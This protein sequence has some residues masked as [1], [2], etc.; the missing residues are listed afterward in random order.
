MKRVVW[1]AGVAA[2]VVVGGCSKGNF[3][4]RESAGKANV[5]RYPL[6]TN[7][8]TLDPGMVQD[9]D[10]IDFLQNVYEGLVG[11]GTDNQP[12]GLIAQNW[13]IKDGGKT[14][15]FHL[16]K[17]VKFFNG[18][19]VHADDFK[20]TYERN[21][22][23]QF[24]SPVTA[25]LDD[26]VGVKDE[27]AGKRNDIPGVKVIDPYTLEVDLVAPRPYFLGRFTYLVAAVLCKEAV[28][29]G[30]EINTT[31]QMVG[32]GPFKCAQFVP[33]QIVVLEA[34]KDYHDGAPQV[35]KIE[36]PIMRDAA[37]RLNKFKAGEVDLVQLERQDVTSLQNDTQFKTELHY[38]DR[39]SIYYIGLNQ[40]AV[41][42]FKN[43]KVRQAIAM[44]IDKQKIV[45]DILGGLVTPANSIIPPGCL[46]HRD[47]AKVWPF[48]ING[49]KK[50][51]TDAGY[52]D[53]TKF[54]E[55]TLKYRGDRPD[56][57]LVAEAVAGQLSTNLGIKVSLLSMDWKA[58]LTSWDAGQVGFFHMRWAADFLDP[59]NFL[60]NMMATYGEE[61]RGL[62]YNNP[63]FDKLC[64]QADGEQDPKKRLDLYAQ[65]E[66]MVLQDAPWIPIY[67][68][69]D[70]ELISPRVQGLRDSLF[71]HLPHTTVHLTQ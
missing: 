46:G 51:L 48:D 3:S 34:N 39:P 21:C 63:A 40:D 25:Y 18:R 1:F 37:T 67:F 2:L 22:N 32:T 9:G 43:P 31:A 66:D 55:L 4:Q 64:M 12:H 57:R 14:Y 71:G 26:I 10:T 56:V 52:A 30:K 68:Q 11:W 27:V 62:K 59:Q 13:D 45:G 17:G 23:H 29:D 38:Y 15:I 44:A 16:K 47:N 7:P 35:E 70:T 20:W 60:S 19:E 58:Y 54:P 8:T 50:A 36:R 53:P 49:A 69:R 24:A 6:V 41:P 33:E 5:F 28:S 65:A 61:D 42:V